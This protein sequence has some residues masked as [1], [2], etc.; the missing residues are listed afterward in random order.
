[1]YL[2]QFLNV[3]NMCKIP[4]QNTA[5]VHLSRLEKPGMARYETDCL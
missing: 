1:M 4:G 2:G 3:G 5:I